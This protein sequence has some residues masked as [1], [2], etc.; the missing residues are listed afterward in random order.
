MS[1]SYQLTNHL[2]SALFNLCHMPNSILPCLIIA[3]HWVTF[4]F[5][6]HKFYGVGLG[7][8]NPSLS[9]PNLYMNHYHMVVYFYYGK[10]IFHG[11]FM[12]QNVEVPWTSLYKIVVFIGFIFYLR[13]LFKSCVTLIIVP[14]FKVHLVL[15]LYVD[16]KI[17][18]NRFNLSRHHRW[19]IC[20][21]RYC[22]HPHNIKQ[23]C[24]IGTLIPWITLYFL[25]GL[26]DYNY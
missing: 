20:H 7:L 9:N 19:C 24:P 17:I 11:N 5:T 3:I 15:P 14:K 23:S 13:Y 12:T 1:W 4:W 18:F 10:N 6:I 2:H 21:K 8:S 22:S 25:D 26:F 16:M